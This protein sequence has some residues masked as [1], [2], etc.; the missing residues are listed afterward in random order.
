MSSKTDSTLPKYYDYYIVDRKVYKLDEWI[1]KHPGGTAW[2]V[3]A[4]GRDISAA[5]HA[6]HASPSSIL[7]ILEK[8][9]VDVP[10]NDAIDPLLNVP[11]FIL[12]EV[13]DARTDGIEFNWEKPDSFLDLTL[14]KIN[15][16][17]MR[18]KIKFADRMFDLTAISLFVFHTFMAFYG[19]YHELLS[20]AAFAVLFTVTRTSLAA[21]GH[22]H[23][24]RRKDGVKDWG[25]ALFDMQYVGANIILADGHVM[26]HHLYTN[27]AADVKRT[28]FTGLLDLPRLW[29][30]PINTI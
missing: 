13:F 3:R 7:K 17:E 26:L 12:P 29:R 9:E 8:F 20:I 30:V 11:R 15:T 27:S 16:K 21:V 2:F 4:N 24:H 6:Y 10:Y 19:V 23:C 5:V 22:Y 14:K 28:V 25:D 18:K 1:P